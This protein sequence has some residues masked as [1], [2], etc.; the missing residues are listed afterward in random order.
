VNKFNPDLA[1]DPMSDRLVGWYAGGAV[2]SL[3]LDTE[4]SPAHPA[5]ARQ[6][7][8]AP[9]VTTSGRVYGC[10][11]YPPSAEVFVAVNSVIENVFIYRLSTSSGSDS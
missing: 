7:M 10:F 8:V 11:L 9:K 3:S 2:Y 5:A 4:M 1:Y 6:R